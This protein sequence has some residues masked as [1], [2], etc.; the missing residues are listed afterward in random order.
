MTAVRGTCDVFGFRMH[1]GDSRILR[2]PTWHGAV[3]MVAHGVKSDCACHPCGDMARSSPPGA[4]AV[5]ST[6]PIVALSLRPWEPAPEPSWTPIASNLSAVRCVE[7]A[8]ALTACSPRPIA[9]GARPTGSTWTSLSPWPSL[10]P[11]PLLCPFSL[12]NVHHTRPQCSPRSPPGSGVRCWTTSMC[13]PRPL[14]DIIPATPRLPRPRLHP[15]RAPET[16]CWLLEHCMSLR[17]CWRPCRRRCAWTRAPPPTRL[18]HLLRWCLSRGPRCAA[19]FPMPAAGS[20]TGRALMQPP[21][22]GDRQVN[23]V[24]VPA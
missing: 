12:P 20:T 22:A 18:P 3:P 13:R 2:C 19:P 8:S 4:A 7:L 23:P 15:L 10:C 21:A 14:A 5:D 1:P 6:A 17:S 16:T 9:D 24:R 11:R